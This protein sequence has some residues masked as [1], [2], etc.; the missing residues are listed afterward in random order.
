MQNSALEGTWLGG[1]NVVYLLG[2]VHS[3]YPSP[4]PPPLQGGHSCWPSSAAQWAHVPG[5][6]VWWAPHSETHH[7][8]IH[9]PGS[10]DTLQ[11]R[12]ARSWAL[13]TADWLPH[14]PVSGGHWFLARWRDPPRGLDSVSQCFHSNTSYQSEKRTREK[15]KHGVLYMSGFSL[16]RKQSSRL[17]GKTHVT[18]TEL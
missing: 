6:M 11:H 17:T 13:T 10:S 2:F 9:Q 8:S 5:A 3:S 16:Q 15:T 7:C 18:E 1:L 12:L 4:M 14:P